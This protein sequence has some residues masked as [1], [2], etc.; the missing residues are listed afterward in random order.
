MDGVAQNSPSHTQAFIGGATLQITEIEI[1]IADRVLT[2]FRRGRLPEDFADLRS[3][4]IL[5]LA[6]ILR[7]RNPP[8]PPA[9]V[10]KCVNGFALNWANDEKV[11]RELHVSTDH[12]GR[13]DQDRAW[14][15]K[16]LP[17]PQ[18]RDTNVQIL[19]LRKLLGEGMRLLSPK[20]KK[21][22]HLRYW[23][24]L[25]GA[26]LTGAVGVGKSY[27]SDLEISAR[28]ALRGFLGNRGINKV[29]DVLGGNSNPNRRR[30]IGPS[31]HQSCAPLTGSSCRR[32]GG[33]TS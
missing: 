14:D 5:K 23:K 19:N 4:V 6:T 1:A 9:Y 18:K 21:V 20:Q 32:R 3:V 17:S 7:D 30:S 28:E 10:W 2:S 26:D 8:I 33:H 31:N 16:D 12:V 27:V 24:D 22:L 11:H 15:P 25:H 13:D 29:T